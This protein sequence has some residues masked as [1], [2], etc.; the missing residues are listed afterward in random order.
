MTI[1]W[2]WSSLVNCCDSLWQIHKQ[3][4]DTLQCFV[5]RLVISLCNKWY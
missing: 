1:N 2:N 5:L 4:G 3:F